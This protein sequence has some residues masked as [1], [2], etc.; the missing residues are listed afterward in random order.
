M[1]HVC[2][3]SAVPAGIIFAEY[4]WTNRE[5]RISTFVGVR[6]RVWP[7]TAITNL[8]A[9]SS[10][11]RKKPSMSEAAALREEIIVQRS[12]E[13]TEEILNAIRENQGTPMFLIIERKMRRLAQQLKGK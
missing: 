1:T 13:L 3:P 9:P 11:K 5:G 2:L 8:K 4:E 7:L 10:R 12:A 6:R